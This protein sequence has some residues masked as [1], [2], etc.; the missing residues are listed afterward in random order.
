M[1]TH[2]TGIFKGELSDYSEI[3]G[4]FQLHLILPAHK[5]LLPPVFGAI[6]SHMLNKKEV[7]YEAS[8]LGRTTKISKAHSG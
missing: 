8:E 4:G 7:L 6:F 3:A 2:V 1:R 5:M